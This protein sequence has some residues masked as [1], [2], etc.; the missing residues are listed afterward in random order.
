MSEIATASINTFGTTSPKA[1]F[2]PPSERLITMTIGQL[3]DL[4]K[5][6]VEKAILPL[7]ERIESLEATV[8]RQDEKIA[9]LES[10]ASLH[11]EN[12]FIQLRLIGQLR[13]AAQKTA[14]PPAPPKGTKTLARLAK[15]DEILKTRRATTLK[16]L[17]RILGIDRATMT[18]LLARLDM[19]R[20]E[21]HSRP[22]DDR[23]K[24]LRL[25]AQIR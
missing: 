2:V 19:R 25:K 15:I 16:E 24:V 4:I 18:R 17:E 23:E 22:G 3:Q 20:Y 21:I 11:E 12:L 5:E 7:Q 8:A 13:E 10:T 14:T 6:A 9:A 1:D